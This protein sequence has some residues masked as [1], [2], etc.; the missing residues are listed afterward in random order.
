MTVSRPTDSLEAMRRDAREILAAGT[1][2]GHPRALV[3]EHVAVAETTIR[4]CGEEYDLT[5]YEEVVV[6]GGGNAAGSIAA[7]LERLLGTR[8]T[9]GLVVTDTPV[10]TETVSVREGDHPLPSHRNYTAS[11][12]ILSLA[13]ATT[14]DT[15]VV[16][17]ITG[18]GSALLCAPIDSV[19]LSELQQVTDGLLSAGA[20]VSDVNTVRRT[21]SRIK[22]GGLA[23]VAAPADV[24]G[25]ILSDVVGDDPA[26][27]ASGPTVPQR[28]APEDTRRILDR[29]DV[30]ISASVKTTLG[31]LARVPS[32]TSEP[33]RA[34]VE[35]H[36]LKGNT[37]AL[38]AAGDRA[39]EAGYTPLLL[40]SQIRGEAA[41]IAKM[42]VAIAEECRQTGHPIEPPAALLSGGETTVTV[43]GEGTGGPNQEFC[44]SAAIELDCEG[45]VVAAVDTDGRDGATDVAGGLVA[46]DTVTDA[47]RMEAV[48]ALETNDSQQP[49][50]A[51]DALIDTGDTGTNVNDLRVVLVAAT[52][53]RGPD[54]G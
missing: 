20:D 40:S 39:R 28:S 45:T 6:L 21:L 3:D 46:H 17:P 8:L 19:S 9:D 35:N 10:E 24:V 27:V 5:R 18:G 4:I 47:D 52:G 2:A 51:A 31:Q 54:A 23:D 43:S 13:A 50:A 7:E 42:H 44:L 30:E 16:A 15:L 34:T 53:H 29:Y 12:E 41:E 48:A 49:L 25:V 22:G 38:H 26:V 11:A 14:S 32:R 33:G 37:T 1:Q 36:V